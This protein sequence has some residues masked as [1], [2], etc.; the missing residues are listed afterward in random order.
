MVVPICISKDTVHE[1]SVGYDIGNIKGSTRSELAHN[2]VIYYA[3]EKVS[4]NHSTFSCARHD[5]VMQAPGVTD[6]PQQARKAV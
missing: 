3:N 2:L 6:N 1:A 4:L 5:Q